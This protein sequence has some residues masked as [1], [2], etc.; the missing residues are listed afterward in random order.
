MTKLNAQDAH[1]QTAITM[2]AMNTL[3]NALAA[4]REVHATAMLLLLLL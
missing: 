3:K 1:A 2:T 4:P